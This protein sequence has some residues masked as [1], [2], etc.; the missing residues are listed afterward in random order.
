MNRIIAVL[1]SSIFILG[2]ILSVA[3]AAQQ[4]EM[5][6]PSPLPA[7]RVDTESADRSGSLGEGNNLG[8]SDTDRKIIK[9]GY[10]TLEVENIIETMDKVASMAQD[11]GGYVVSSNKHGSDNDE[12]FGTMSIRIPAERFD[13]TLAKLRQLA[14]EVPNES[15]DSRDVTEEYTDLESQLHNLEATEA[16]YL[17]L[18]GKAETV[19]DILK[20]HEELSNVRGQ[21]EHIKGRM[22]YIERTSDMSL[23]EI[24][25]QEVTSIDKKGWSASNTFLSAINGFI[26]FLTALA[27]IA[28]WFLIFCPIWIPVVVILVRRRRKKARDKQEGKI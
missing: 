22:Q 27:S 16:Q 19:E 25:L 21:I 28:I 14:I 3:C 6:A 7:P 12:I 1:V 18:L 24:S 10:I 20:V 13:E 9:T 11:L 8:S 15:T 26:T 17:A 23:I 4:S 5:S 2:I